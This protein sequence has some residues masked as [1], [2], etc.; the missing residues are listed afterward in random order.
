MF[1][2]LAKWVTQID[3]AKRIPE[4]CRPCVDVATKRSA[5]PV[6]IA[7]SG[8]A[9]GSVVVAGFAAR[10]SYSRVPDP[11]ALTRMQN[12]TGEGEEADRHRGGIMLDS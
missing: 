12:A 11:E 10:Q 9:A 8:D 2:P 4:V 3:H 5:R 1:A 6:V 7:L